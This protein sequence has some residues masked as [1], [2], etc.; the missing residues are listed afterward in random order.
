MTVLPVPAETSAIIDGTEDLDPVPNP[1]PAEV[2]LNTTYRTE[3]V[4]LPPLD[5][6]GICFGRL[7]RDNDFVLPNL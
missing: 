3:R 4:F 1:E 6:V 7:Y 2:T 5:E